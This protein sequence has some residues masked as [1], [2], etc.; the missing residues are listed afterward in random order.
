VELQDDFTKKECHT[1]IA[2]TYLQLQPQFRITFKTGSM[3][4][5]SFVLLLLVTHTHTHTHFCHFQLSRHIFRV[6]YRRYVYVCKYTKIYF[7]HN[8]CLCKCL[9]TYK[10]QRLMVILYYL[11]LSNRRVNSMFQPSW[12]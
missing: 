3:E 10:Y 4:I 5:S 6:L 8:S 11:T 7:I 1:E 12:F 2:S 9:Y